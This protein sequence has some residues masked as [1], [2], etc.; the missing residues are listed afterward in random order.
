MN[1][2]NLKELE[3]LF[4]KLLFILDKHGDG[5]IKIQK[6]IVKNTLDIIRSDMSDYK[7]VIKVKKNYQNLYPARGGL[8]EFYIWRDNFEER[9]RLNEPLDKIRERLWQIFK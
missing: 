5:T 1:E 3:K 9:K 7:K 8:S 4:Q 6:R 2:F